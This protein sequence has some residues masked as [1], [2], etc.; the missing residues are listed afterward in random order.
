MQKQNYI[1]RVFG[2]LMLCVVMLTNVFGKQLQTHSYEQI[3]PKQEKKH[4]EETPTDKQATVSSLS[5][6]VVVPSY[7]FDFAHDSIFIPAPQIYFVIVEQSLPY[8]AN[9]S[10]PNT[11]LETIFENLIAPN[12]P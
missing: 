5:L 9:S 1:S 4:T 6:E 2:V 7:A 12:A 10:I 3:K 11:F 8:L